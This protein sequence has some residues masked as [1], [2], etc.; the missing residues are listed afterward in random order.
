MR[1]EIS[2]TTM[3][4]VAVDLGPGEALY[5]QTNCMAW[6]SDNI[7]MNTHTGGGLFAGLKR[8]LSG[9]SLFITDFTA[10]DPVTL[11]LRRVFRA[12]SSRGIWRRTSP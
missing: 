7:Q 12:P 1:Y 2:G 6:M 5:S 4:T 8:S 9:G 3:Q 10:M 11:H